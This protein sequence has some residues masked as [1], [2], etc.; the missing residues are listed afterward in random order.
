MA[1]ILKTI[2]DA[3]DAA[4]NRIAPVWPLKH[5]VAVNPFLGLADK[6]F[7]EAANVMAKAAGAKM[8]MP[9]AY[10]LEAV[11]AGRISDDALADALAE[12]TGW[13]GVRAA[14]VPPS[15]DALKSAARAIDGSGQPPLP[16]LVDALSKAH[17]MD[18]S[19][20]ATDRLSLWAA[21]Y[22]D[23]GQAPWA[24]NGRSLLPYAA[25]RQDG[26]IDRTPEFAGLTG[27]RDALDALPDTST[28]LLVA[29]RDRLDL[30]PDALADYFHRALMSIGGWAA[31]ARYQVWQSELYGKENP[32]LKELLAVRVAFDL[33]ALA[34]CDD[35]AFD[36]WRSDF[37]TA[38][39][40]DSHGGDTIVLSILQLAHERAWQ[41][42]IKAQLQG[43]PQKGGKRVKGKGRKAVQAA[44]C[45]DVRSEVMRRALESISGDV[46]TIGFAGFF[47]FPIEYVPLGH[48][49][50]GAQCPVLLTP[51]FTVCETVRDSND[52]EQT[53]LLG[54]RL[55][56]RR[57]AN[58]FKSF[59]SAAVSSFAFVETMGWTYA[60]KLATDALGFTRPVA[61][62]ASDG[63]DAPVRARLQPSITSKD[64]AGRT[65]G[66]TDQTRVDMAQGVLGAMS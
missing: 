39:A 46:E 53:E 49:E 23:E 2:A 18:W 38:R 40:D 7:H 6:P 14:Q 44:F 45:I 48:S 59:K 37:L 21:G 43:K 54:L 25:W 57:A 36:A 66:F 30:P 55:M 9:A 50:G 5:F 64:V 63:I 19:S 10:Y 22:F 29:A 16:T 27:F 17:G 1:K 11:E 26:R 13:P 41:G 15:I 62:P 33:A 34:A 28:G 61:D 12:A 60:G 32:T 42:H 3:V 31:Y 20:F 8:T 35:A 51:K 52:D 56:R 4:C 58:A 24:S 47:G 65:T